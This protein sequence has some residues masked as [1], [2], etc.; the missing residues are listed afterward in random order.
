MASDF[1][2]DI[3]EQAIEEIIVEEI[4]NG[5]SEE[6]LDKK[7]SQDA[8][9]KA[10]KGLIEQASEHSIETIENMMY[11][12]VLEERS[13][14]DLFLARQNQKWRN[15]FVASD[16]MYICILESAESYTEYV[17]EIHG[18]DICQLFHA[19]RYIHGRALQIYLEINCLNKN[20]FADGAYAR[21]RS[22]YELSI[23]SAFIKKYGEK[24]AKAFIQSANTDDRY[25]WAREADCFKNYNKKYITFSAIQ[26]NC[27]LATK[28]W[29]EEY[30]FV[31]QLVHASPQG[32]MYRLG[33]DTSYSLPVGRTDFGMT[34][35]AVHSAIS[36]SQITGDFFT[37]YSH[38]DSILAVA[39]FH[40]W[41]DRIIKYY[42]GVEN[43][44]NHIESDQ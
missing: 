29:K 28:E 31:N 33:G 38:G 7:L 26:D 22:L 43:N 30:N 10:Y 3:M 14:A 34:I 4:S 1:M 40:K 20:G 44:T 23:M 19:L 8:I 27:E 21:W 37:V 32:T 39:T 36:L 16:A 41:I 35:S 42:K 12:K 5:I 9:L 11:E 15:A 6:K 24:V 17:N 2:H 18:Q 25:E 13:E